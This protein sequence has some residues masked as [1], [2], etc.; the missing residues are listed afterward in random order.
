MWLLQ[1]NIWKEAKY[2]S[3]STLLERYDIDL[4]KLIQKIHNYYNN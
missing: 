2:N 1:K 3:L 4:S